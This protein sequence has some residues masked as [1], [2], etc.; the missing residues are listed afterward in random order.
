MCMEFKV[1]FHLIIIESRSSWHPPG[2][3]IAQVQ[4]VFQIPTA[5]VSKFPSISSHAEQIP[6]YLAYIEWFNPIPAMPNRSH[7]MYQVSRSF[8]RGH[9]WASIIPV[10]TIFS[11]IHLFLRI[12]PDSSPCEGWNLFTVL[13]NCHSFY[14]N[15]FS[16]RDT[17]LLFS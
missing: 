9:R 8:N 2:H 6:T 11:S 3:R 14:V 1:G 5:A 13:D 7:G 15:P 12:I 16:D 10:D 17:F 4:V